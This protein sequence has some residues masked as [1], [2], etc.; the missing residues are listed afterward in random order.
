V[1]SRSALQQA[2]KNV[3][4]H[5]AAVGVTE[6]MEL[7]FAVLEKMLPR[8]FDGAVDRYRMIKRVN[9]N[10]HE[11]MSEEA[12]ASLEKDMAIEVEFY[13]FVRQRLRRTA[14]AFGATISN[15]IPIQTY[16]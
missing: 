2:K 12:R 8:F 6:D 7:S 1:G 16:R 13:H 3:E 4:C 15:T 5:Y 14:N 10:Q 11:N 9:R